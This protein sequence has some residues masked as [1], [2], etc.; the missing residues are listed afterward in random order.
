MAIN[1]I[2]EKILFQRHNPSKNPNKK[3][4]INPY[5]TEPK[6]LNRDNNEGVLVIDPNKIVDAYNEIKDRYIKQEDLVIYAS[7][8]AYKSGQS[9]VVHNASTGAKDKDITNEPIYINFLNPRSNTKN[10]NGFYT[11]KG[12]L[13]SEWADFF[14]SDSAN[15][16]ENDKYIL[17][18]ESFGITNI[19][20]KIN[21]NQH[22]VITIEFTDVQGRVLFERGNDKDNPYNIFYTFPYPKFTLKYKGY[23]GKAVETQLVLIKSNTRFDPSTGNYNIT[24]EFQSDVFSILNT[25][26][27]IYAYVAPYMFKLDNGEYLGGKILKQLYES[28]NAKIKNEVGDDDFP[29]YEILGSPTLFDLAGA[30]KD[31]PIDALNQSDETNVSI[32]AN[33]TLIENKIIIENYEANVRDYFVSN[34][35]SYR[36]T[37]I[38]NSVFYIPISSDLTIDITNKTPLDFFEKIQRINKAIEDISNISFPRNQ[39]AFLSKI[40]NDIKQNDKLK[41]YYSNTDNLRGE[42]IIQPNLFLDKTVPSIDGQTPI[43]L[44][45]F[46]TVLG[47]V[48]DAI[49]DVQSVVEEDSINDQIRDLGVNLGYQPTLSNILR[50][51]SNN[52]QTFITMLDIMGKSANN[53]LKVDLL[54]INTQNRYSETPKEFD[55]SVYT[56]FPN[57]FK[58]ITER[59][60][61]DEEPVEKL[62]LDYPGVNNLNNKWF[63]VR[64]VEEIYEAIN[65]IKLKA[66]PSVNGLV[67]QKPTGLLSVFQLG[68]EDLGVYGNK[69]YGRVLAEAFSRY[70]IYMSYSGLL[71]RG[72]TNLPSNISAL[73]ADFE[74]DLI[75]KNV[76]SKL[77]STST[78]FV[79][80]NDIKTATRSLNE[81]NE[82]YSNLG[83]FGIKFIGFGDKTLNG[84]LNVLRP[85][86]SDLA[87]YTTG[88]Y[89]RQEYT[90]GLNKLTKLFNSPAKPNSSGQMVG[91]GNKVVYSKIRYTNLNNNINLYSSIRDKKVNPTGQFID[92]KPNYSYYCDN[93]GILRDISE[94]IRNID[95]DKVN[96]NNYQGLYINMNNNLKS[97][98][99]P[100]DLSRT[101]SQNLND[102][103]PALTFNTKNDDYLQMRDFSPFKK[104]QRTNTDEN[105]YDTFNLI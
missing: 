24:A 90:N 74:T 23:Y 83:N 96:G 31:I 5:L 10:E 35:E 61:V 4:V 81:D 98:I 57:Y 80:A 18:P 12:K 58:K 77:Q 52:M 13:T 72:I 92:L 69:E 60:G 2:D 102:D 41:P 44:D 26:L 85:V 16:K 75:L 39:D 46:N 40:K 21:A 11:N 59:R 97:I 82:S 101:V 88:S 27:I 28:Q 99:T 94:N 1:G 66:N 51:I 48:S 17:D 73:I 91:I 49:S 38:E 55:K 71:Y 43:T 78:K 54:R 104:V 20:I 30:L 67:Q 7:L 79:L 9:S 105:F 63:E 56:A 29:K 86:F 33:E 100:T 89:T 6:D 19:G 14:T 32:G 53:Q 22:P 37:T 84:S 47:I 42:N 103:I 3:R 70:A 62:V 8:K 68:E 93:S 34:P 64:F 50:I 45:F 25:F 87:K 65:I 76:Y 15:D 36:I 95:G